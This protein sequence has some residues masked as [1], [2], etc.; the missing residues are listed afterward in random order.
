M[1]ITHESWV[2]RN[3]IIFIGIKKNRLSGANK[4]IIKQKMHK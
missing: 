4:L 1:S 3:N 2:R